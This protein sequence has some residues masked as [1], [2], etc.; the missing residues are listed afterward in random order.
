MRFDPGKAWP[1]PVLR[2]S[3]YGDDYP[4]GEFEVET[5]V[6]RVKG[7]TAVEVYASF[8]LSLS[9]PD[10]YNSSTRDKARFALYSGSAPKTS[11]SRDDL[12]FNQTSR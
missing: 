2:P 7:S 10:A 11:F 5:E 8:E 9:K 6:V 12:P 4:Q 3:S 1:H